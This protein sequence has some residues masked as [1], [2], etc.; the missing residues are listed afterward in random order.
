MNFIIHVPYEIQWNDQK[1]LLTVWVYSID[2]IIFFLFFSLVLLITFHPFVWISL[3]FII[4]VWLMKLY[5]LFLINLFSLYFMWVNNIVNY[6]LFCYY[7]CEI[8]IEFVLYELINKLNSKIVIYFPI[9]R[10]FVYQ[11]LHSSLSQL[12]YWY[13]NLNSARDSLK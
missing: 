9:I 5:D 12:I 8:C 7:S 6:N 10:I 2:H 11:R 4:F 3:F 13:N 1:S